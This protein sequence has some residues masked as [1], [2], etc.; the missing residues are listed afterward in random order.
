MIVAMHAHG[1]VFAE[2]KVDPDLG[3]LTGNALVENL[4][5]QPVLHVGPPSATESIH[6][7]NSIVP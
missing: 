6:E 1:A 4:A 7:T 2:A 3:Q 5:A